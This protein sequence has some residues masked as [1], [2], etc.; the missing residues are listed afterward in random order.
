[1]L[2]GHEITHAFD[3]TGRQYDKDGNKISW[4][5]NETIDAFNQSK[6]CI[7]S[8]YNNYT[9]LQLQKQVNGILTQGENIADNGGLKA[10][11]YV[12]CFLVILMEN[13]D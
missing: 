9:L 5:T 3:G 7:I 13:E 12:R 4:W 6:T 11:F 10:A 1:M 2:I 8:Q